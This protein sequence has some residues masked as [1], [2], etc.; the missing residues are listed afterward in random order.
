MPGILGEDCL[1]DGE[2]L[3]S[4]LGES[5]L[6]N[7]NF[8][9]GGPLDIEFIDGTWVGDKL[10]KKGWEVGSRKGLDLD[11]VEVGDKIGASDNSG[12]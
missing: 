6:I 8:E 5:D 11:G 1:D 12:D 3:G 2:S 7:D 10:Y 4:R 9:V